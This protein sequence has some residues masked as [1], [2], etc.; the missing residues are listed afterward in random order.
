VDR[1]RRRSR[2]SRYIIDRL[3]FLEGGAIHVWVIERF[4]PEIR[5]T[6]S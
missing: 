6:F 5:P 1:H 4:P 2:H 3:G